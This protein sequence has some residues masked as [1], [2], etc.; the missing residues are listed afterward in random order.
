MKKI[1]LKILMD[2]H[3]LSHPKYEKNGFW[4]AVFLYVWMCAL[5]APESGKFDSYLAFNGLSS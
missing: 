5:L 4:N 3:V 1:D 2:L